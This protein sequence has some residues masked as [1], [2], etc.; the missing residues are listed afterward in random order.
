MTCVLLLVIKHR[1]HELLQWLVPANTT[2]LCF[3]VW[4]A[5]NAHTIH[6]V[7]GQF[8]SPMGRLLLFC[9]GMT[10]HFHLSS[11]YLYGLRL[12]T[13]YP[14]VQ[15]A[16]SLCWVQANHTDHAESESQSWPEVQ[17]LLPAQRLPVFPRQYN[18][19]HL[20]SPKFRVQEASQQGQAVP[21]T[22]SLSSRTLPESTWGPD[23][24]V[25][26]AKGLRLYGTL[27]PRGQGSTCTSGVTCLG[28][29]ATSVHDS[30]PEAPGKLAWGHRLIL[31]PSHN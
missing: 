31:G 28:P 1:C 25:T 10:D 17:D 6:A 14:R 19:G 2:S 20:P 4:A 16:T 13:K 30:K 26:K 12:L 22:S 27:G 15:R 23:T 24:A 11:Q 3:W 21:H 5:P 18:F 8:Q 29:I 7:G 9:L